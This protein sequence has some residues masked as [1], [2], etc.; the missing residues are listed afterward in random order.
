MNKEVDNVNYEN[1]I[2]RQQL[3]NER[4]KQESLV[5]QCDE[6]MKYL[7]TEVDEMKKKHERLIKKNEKH[8]MKI[9]EENKET[10]QKLK[11]KEAEVETV[12][13]VLIEVENKIFTYEE[14]IERHKKNLTKSES[15]NRKL[16]DTNRN[17]EEKVILCQKD[18]SKEK[19]LFVELKR[20]TDQQISELEAK[21]NKYLL[22]AE[23][24]EVKIAELE[25]TLR[26]QKEQIKTFKSDID[27]KAE[28][29]TKNSTLEKI[30][31]NL[32]GVLRFKDAKINHLQDENKNLKEQNERNAEKHLLP[33]ELEYWETRVSSLE[34]N[35]KVLTIN[36][37]TK[38][39]ENQI[40]NAQIDT[41][42]KEN[43]HLQQL[44]SLNE[45]KTVPN[46]I[47]A[48]PKV[49]TC[50]DLQQM[51][52]ETSL[53][54]VTELE[55]ENDMLHNKIKEMQRDFMSS[56][57][58]LYDPTSDQKEPSDNIREDPDTMSESG[59]TK[60]SDIEGSVASSLIGDTDE[61]LLAGGRLERSSYSSFV[62]E[63]VQQEVEREQALLLRLQSR[64]RD[65][66]T[67]CKHIIKYELT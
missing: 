47:N 15:E 38:I 23:G 42:R 34:E 51:I 52:L 39:S 55:N 53:L 17:L 9:N 49:N 30:N 57:G 33:H 20:I 22:Q 10:I 3:T 36:L 62:D 28:L 54:G 46:S 12:N 41:L 21:S 16:K 4:K 8:Q 14:Q 65:F 63:F 61:S 67:N 59:I 44:I 48:Q 25:T 66:D 27:T 13:N 32:Q 2:L 50:N 60:V 45:N 31:K 24:Q 19:T 7:K 37:D 1:G 11:T 35:L 29:I 5:L 26:K 43:G 6:K 64:V 40:V 58:T 56:K 18:L